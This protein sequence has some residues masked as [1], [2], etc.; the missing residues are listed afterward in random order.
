MA[1]KVISVVVR[2]SGKRRGSRMERNGL[3]K[4]IGSNGMDKTPR[5]RLNA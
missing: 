1:T 4:W 2:G 3:L 5:G